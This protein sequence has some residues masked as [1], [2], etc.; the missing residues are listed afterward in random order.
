MRQCEVGW[1]LILVGSGIVYELWL[2]VP[3]WLP[4]PLSPHKFVTVFTGRSVV[5]IATAFGLG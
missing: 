4:H 3:M 2:I 1:M 5:V